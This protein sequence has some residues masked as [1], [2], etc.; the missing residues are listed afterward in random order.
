MRLTVALI[1]VAILI[2]IGYVGGM[3]TGMHF[4]FGVVIP[5]LAVLTFLAGF[6]V[7]VVQWAKV[8]VPYRIPTTAGQQA[9]LAGIE[10]SHLDNPSTMLGVVGRMALEVLF[11][12][13]LI[14]NTF[15]ELRRNE[16]G[17]AKVLYNSNLWLWGF[18]LAFHWGFLIILFRH[19]RFFTAPVPVFVE[20]VDF[21]DGIAQI[22][23]PVLYITD[24]LIVAGLSFLF[25]RRLWSS[26]LRYISLPG[27]YFPVVLILCIALSGMAMRYLEPFR[28]DIEAVKL[29][30]MSLVGFEFA[31]PEEPIGH[32]FYIHL[33]LVC[34]L[35]T[36]FPFSKL[37]HMGGVFLS[38]TRNLANNNR[39]VT[40]VNPWKLDAHPHTYA[41]YEDEFRSKMKAVGLPLDREPEPESGGEKEEG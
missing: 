3:V 26:Q 24:L 30:G 11:F 13:S 15:V 7:R 21:L 18:S 37:M 14:R 38:P 27:D 20:L 34:S 33:F 31:L 40:H 2:A 6:I 5:Y 1:A 10:P 19:M 12:R 17:T 29:L 8:P 39:A 4:L 9:S 28:V 16:D 36:Y 32:W 41:E 23:V 22:G 35:I 25:V